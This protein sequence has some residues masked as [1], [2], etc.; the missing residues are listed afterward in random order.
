MQDLAPSARAQLLTRRSYN[1]NLDEEGKVFETWADTVDRSI[2]HQRWLWETAQGEDLIPDQVEELER[3]RVIMLRRR[4]VLAGRTLWLGG[5]ELV[6]RRQASMFNCAF[7]TV[8]SVH[9]VVDI[10]WLLLQGCGTGFLP[11]NGVLSGFIRKM[12]VEIVRS[13]KV[14]GDP[15]GREH[16][17]ESF[18]PETKIWTI[19]IGDSAEA[20]AKSVGKIIAGK[21]PARKLRLVLSEIRAAGQRLKGY[22]WICSGDGP[23][24]QALEAICAILNRYAGKMLSKEALWDIVN[25]LGTVLSSRRSAQIGLIDFGDPEWETI[26][27]R[28]Y[29]GF[30]KTPHWYRSQSNNTI[31]F[32]ERP[33]KKQLKNL[34]DLIVENGGSEP[35]FLN[36]P[37]A[38]NRAP[39]FV[40]LNPC[41]TYDTLVYVADG[42]GKV[43]IGK[44]AEEGKDVPVFCKATDGDLTI[45]MMRNP[46]LTGINE[47]IYKVTLDDGS[48]IRTTGNHKFLLREG[49]YREVVNLK[50]GD[51]LSLLTKYTPEKCTK[52]SYADKYITQSYHGK[53]FIEHAMLAKFHFGVEADRELH[54]HHKDGNRLN[55]H[56]ANLEIKEAEFHLSDHGVGE[57]NGNFSGVS[58]ENLIT[59]GRELAKKLGR[60]FSKKEWIEFAKENNLPQKF[61]EWRIQ[62]LGT[63]IAFATRCAYME[64]IINY[65]DQDPRTVRVF[66]EMIKS[67]FDAE[68]VNRMVMITKECEKCGQPFKVEHARR[69][70]GFC[71]IKCSRRPLTT[72]ENAA[73]KV[74][75]N[76]AHDKRREKKSKEQLDVYLRLKVKLGRQPTKLEWASACKAEK[77]SAEISRASS[78]FKSWAALVEAAEVVNHK[79]VSVE[80]DGYENVYNGTVDEFHNFFVGGWEGG[81]TKEGRVREFW[82]T[83]VQC[84][85]V[86]LADKGFCNLVETDLYK[87]RDDSLALHEAITLIA[88]ANFRQTCVN[89]RDGILQSSWHETNEYLRLCGVGI[90]GI[91]RKHGLSSY[92][93]RQLRYAAITAAYSMADELGL[94]RP[95]NVTTI[96]PSG[97]L[98][99]CMDTTEGAHKPLARHILNNAIFSQHDPLV[100]RMIQNGYK[101]SVHPNDPTSVLAVIP[102]PLFDDVDMTKVGNHWIDCESAIDQLRRYGMLQRNFVDQNTSI[103]IS[104]EKDEIKEI[105]NYLDKHWDDNYVATSWCLR[106][107]P[108]KTAEDLGYSYLPQECVTQDVYENYVVGLKHIDIE[109]LGSLDTALE[110]ECRNGVC[111]VR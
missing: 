54:V 62:S 66:N 102:V 80:E 34:F 37:A 59:K 11:T 109:R 20:W 85:E 18:D 83:N 94:E 36:Y 1:R 68:I 2:S 67:G 64:G 110:D 65:S 84:G 81:Y 72:E 88:R 24:A 33:S 100:E 13:K 99:K 8:R 44:L 75:I 29:K 73:L 31:V 53:T 90:T 70:Q 17:I 46:R 49:G 98:S 76:A 108:L 26:A 5:T 27:T 111:P 101:V 82:L 28:K 92:D 51:S 6:K 61:S 48:T 45:R 42:R 105:V 7:S 9:D 21:Y 71:S 106:N 25:W 58:N 41:L 95:K 43:A 86:L 107:S 50:A 96:K 77:V 91:C 32:K 63:L 19:D 39:W 12:D 4:S 10:F 79:V 23:F 22:G 38:V 78:P 56:P 74:A 69:E 47:K 87:F 40:G 52:E 3:L 55:N 104:Y 60:R 103:T 30:D 14:I 89:L 15:K 93:L 16:N 57:S 35:G 97:T